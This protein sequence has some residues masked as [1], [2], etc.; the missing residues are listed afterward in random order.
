[1]ER[2]QLWEY[3]CKKNPQFRDEGNITLTKRGLKKLFD[4]TFER[5]F[6]RGKEIG[7]QQGE[8]SKS[9]FDEI[10]GKFGK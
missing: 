9:V 4:Q 1:M 10:F 3:Y 8:N 6:E 2:D 7:K 5:G